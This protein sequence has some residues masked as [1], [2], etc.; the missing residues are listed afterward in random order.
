MMALIVSFTEAEQA[1]IDRL[2]SAFNEASWG[3]SVGRAL[4]LA[5]VLI[6]Y[7]RDGKL[8]VIDPGTGMEVELF[9]PNL[10]QS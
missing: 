2:K 10:V 7:I 6:P 5:E 3:D 4:G 1:R 8:V 9:W